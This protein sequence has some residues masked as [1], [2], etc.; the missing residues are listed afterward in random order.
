MLRFKIESL[1]NVNV[2]LS[3]GLNALLKEL[4][5]CRSSNL[6]PYTEPLLFWKKVK[7]AKN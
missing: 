3:V 1:T 4:C 2:N 5:D 6:L 7:Q